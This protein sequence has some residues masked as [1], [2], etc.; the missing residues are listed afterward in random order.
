MPVAGHLFW[1]SG[2]GICLP[3]WCVT[4]SREGAEQHLLASL[5]APRSLAKW[6]SG[7][8]GL[9]M[10][11]LGRIGGG[12]YGCAVGPAVTRGDR[13][14]RFSAKA[15]PRTLRHTAPGC[16]EKKMSSLL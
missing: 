3:N 2:T 6:F 14:M 12:G 13:V 11:R 10:R 1:I 5:P 16:G 8:T 9:A 7:K 15:A 4:R